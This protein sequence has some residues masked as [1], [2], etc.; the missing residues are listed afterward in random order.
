MHRNV[1]RAV[2]RASTGRARSRPEWSGR[3]MSSTIGAGLG[4]WLSS[5]G[6]GPSSAVCGDQAVEVQ[7]RAP[8]RAGSARTRESSSTTRMV[9]VV[10]AFRLLSVVVD[11]VRRKAAAWRRRRGRRSGRRGD[12]EQC[13]AALGAGRSAAVLI[14]WRR[15]YSIGMVSG[16]RAATRRPRSRTARCCPPSKCAS[17][18]EIDRPRPVPPYLPAECCRRPGGRLRKSALL[19][20]R[21]DTDCR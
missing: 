9:R 15:R 3:L 21:S 13:G 12:G 10:R 6:R 17:S 14:R 4:N 5:P 18:R 20:M 11:S 16:E 19:L 7:S 8:G 1:P 2:D